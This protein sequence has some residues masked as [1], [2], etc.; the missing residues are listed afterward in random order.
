MPRRELIEKNPNVFFVFADLHTQDNPERGQSLVSGLE[1]AV[2]LG[3]RPFG[4]AYPLYACFD[5][6][7][8]PPLITPDTAPAEVYRSLLAL[9]Y[10]TGRPFLAPRGM[11]FLPAPF[12]FFYHPPDE[13]LE[14]VY[15][16]ERRSMS[17]ALLD[18]YLETWSPAGCLAQ[19]TR[20][21][22]ALTQEFALPRPDFE[23]APPPI[24]LPQPWLPAVIS[25]ETPVKAGIVVNTLDK[26]GL[27][28][29]VAQLVRALSHLGEDPFVLCVQSGGA[30]AD[31]LKTEGIRVYVADGER[32]MLRQILQREQPDLVNSHLAHLDFLE[33]ANGLGI[34]VIETIHSSYI[35]LNSDEWKN[36]RRRS[37]YFSQ[38]IT[39]SQTALRFYSRWNHYIHP[40]WLEIVPNG[41][42][43][44]H[45]GIPARSLARQELGLADTDFLFLNIASYDGVKNQLGILSAFD[46]LAARFPQ[47]RLICAG[48][49][50]SPDFH[51][52]V[53]DYRKTLKSRERI[54]LFEYRSDV[55][56]LLAGADAFVLNSFSEGWSMAATEAL[57]AGIPLIHS[58]CGSAWELVGQNGE[59]GIVVPNPATEPINMGRQAILQTYLQ[60]RQRNSEALIQAMTSLI[61]GYSTWQ[62]K[63]DQIAAFARD[64]FSAR[65]MAEGYQA[66]FRAVWRKA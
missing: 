28:E 10:T 36:E 14:F 53:I 34:P 46:A 31:Q 43:P 7:W 58:E 38:A 49:I 32:A 35:W 5:A 56:R 57:M 45:L 4:E 47:A 11:H 60:K 55:G 1:N 52:Q 26:G 21:A 65:R 19:L 64:A 12:Q 25:R 50:A 9:S 23:M 27:E 42:D 3:T 51:S 37:R 13:S 17:T 16:L 62:A 41:V 15:Q 33:V 22:D 18:E 30:A 59:R 24:T 61:E 63:R 44:Q 6:L 20:L 54:Q 40:E 2:Y 48:N 29:M 8:L 39:T 66:V